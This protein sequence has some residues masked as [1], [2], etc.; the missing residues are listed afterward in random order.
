MFFWRGASA[1]GAAA[2]LRHVAGGGRDGRPSGT[3]ARPRQ[4]RQD[5]ALRLQPPGRGRL[6]RQT[7]PLRLQPQ[8]EEAQRQW[9]YNSEAVS[10]VNKA[11]NLCSLRNATPCLYGAN[12]L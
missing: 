6:Q 7:L 10:G 9:W 12:E 5:V 4:P 1:G 8:G 3:G 2:A 11:D